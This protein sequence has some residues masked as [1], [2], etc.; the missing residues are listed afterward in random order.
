[1]RSLVLAL[2]VLGGCS[3]PAVPTDF[4]TALGEAAQ[5][6]APVFVLESGAY[7]GSYLYHGAHYDSVWVDLSVRNDAVDKQVGIVWTNDHWSTS[8]TVAAMFE[9]PLGARERWGVDVQ[10]AVAQVGW[11][12]PGQV[13]YAAFVTASGVTSWSP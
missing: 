11:Q 5:R 7:F 2:L 8:H 3:S 12:P 10:N 9:G 6:D 13:E 4:H 1:M